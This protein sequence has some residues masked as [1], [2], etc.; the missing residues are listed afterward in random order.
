MVLQE[1]KLTWSD[2]NKVLLVGG[3]TRMPMVRDMITQISSI[4]VVDDVNPDEAVAVGAA[5]QAI[6]SLL[7]EEEVS[8]VKTLPENTRQQFSARDGGLVQVTNITS[9][10]L[11]VVLWDEGHLEE[12]VFPMIPKMTAMPATAKN[13]FG[14]ASANMRHARVRIVEGESTLPAECTPLGLCD[15]ELPAFLPKGSPV[16][17]TYEYNANQVLEVAVNACGNEAKVTI[18]RN[19]GLAPD[20]VERAKA[21][22]GAIAVA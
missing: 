2:M 4:P 15:V 5:I 21:S 18:E 6:L 8:G 17:L 19:T 20:E 12:Y 10:T 16:E 13:S 22:L 3:M 1:A 7:R 11:G 9:H 14:T